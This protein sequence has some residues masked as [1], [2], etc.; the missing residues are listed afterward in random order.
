M[1]RTFYE[2]LDLIESFLDDETMRIQFTEVSGLISV[3]DVLIDT[4]TQFE[5]LTPAFFSTFV[6]FADSPPIAAFRD[7]FQQVGLLPQAVTIPMIR[8]VPLRTRTQDQDRLK[9]QQTCVDFLNQRLLVNNWT[10]VFE[11][12]FTL[13]QASILAFYD[14]HEGFSNTKMIRHDASGNL[15]S[16]GGYEVIDTVF[17]LDK[18]A[19]DLQLRVPNS[20]NLLDRQ[21]AM[22]LSLQDTVN[23]ERIIKILRPGLNDVGRFALNVRGISNPTRNFEAIQGAQGGGHQHFFLIDRTFPN[24]NTIDYINDSLPQQGSD[25]NESTKFMAE[26]I[27][28]FLRSLGDQRYYK[29]RIFEG[30]SRQQIP[31]LSQPCNITQFC[32]YAALLSGVPPD[33]I[34]ETVPTKVSTLLYLMQYAVQHPSVELVTMLQKLIAALAPKL[35]LVLHYQPVLSPGIP[36]EENNSCFSW[37]VDALS[38]IYQWFCDMLTGLAHMI[39]G[40]AE[41]DVVIRPSI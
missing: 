22:N 11:A 33:A 13:L 29:L 34:C 14:D 31:Y 8:D 5:M 3:N 21:S 12:Y 19:C 28:L 26:Q 17:M 1:S 27:V 25:I 23:A 30:K 16:S 40:S 37:L 2:T 36:V 9:Q 41:D 15:L 10:Q 18:G 7:F 6:P 35:Q 32:T 24:I 20:R 4:N 38:A 39:S